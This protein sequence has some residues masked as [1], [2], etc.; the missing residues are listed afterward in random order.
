MLRRL[1]LHGRQG[2]GELDQ[3]AAQRLLEADVGEGSRHRD[4]GQGLGLRLGEPGEARAPF[5]E[6][7]HPAVRPPLRVDG[8]SRGRQRVE[9]AVDRPLRDLEPFREITGFE[10]LPGLKQQEQAQKAVGPH[11]EKEATMNS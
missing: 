11:D 7:G 4:R 6:E 2:G 1:L 9:V 5:P 10:A 3:A 8:D